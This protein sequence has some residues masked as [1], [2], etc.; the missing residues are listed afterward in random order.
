MLGIEE[1]NSEQIKYGIIRS[2]STS[3]FIELVDH[4]NNIVELISDNLTT[5]V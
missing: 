3:H 5:R 1:N 2:K 4:R